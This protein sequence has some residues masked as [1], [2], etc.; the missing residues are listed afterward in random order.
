M[1]DFTKWWELTEKSLH[2]PTTWQATKEAFRR[3]ALVKEVA[4]MTLQYQEWTALSAYV[5][6]GIIDHWSDK[7]YR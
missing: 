2:H 4:N 6:K 1:L 7:E 3:W 5:L